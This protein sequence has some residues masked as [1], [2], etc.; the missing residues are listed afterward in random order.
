MIPI[1]KELLCTLGP[2]SMN[3]RVIK[4]LEDIGATLFRINLSHTPLDAV[5]RTV[6]LIQNETAVPICLDTEG[7]QIRTGDIV[8]SEIRL[9]ENGVVRAHQRRTAGDDGNF[10]FYPRNIVASL[11]IGDFISIDFDAV[12]VQVIGFEGTGADAV[13]VMRV[14]NGGP[15][16]RNKAVTVARDIALPPMTEKDREAVAIGAALGV[17]HF[18]LSFANCRADVE[19]LRAIAGPDAFVISKIECLRGIA[20]L[21]EIA[22]ASEAILIDRGD[23]SREVPMENIPRVQKQII[24][25]GRRSGVRV[26]VATN[27]LESMVSA[28]SPTRAEVNDIFNTLEDGADG[29]VLAAETA[30]G[31]FPIECAGM[32]VKMIRNFE[33]PGPESGGDSQFSTEPVSLLPEPHGGALV[34][35]EA[36]SAERAQADALPVLAVR[37]TDFMDCEQIA[38]GTYSP[39]QGF[40]DRATLESVLEGNRLPCGAIWTLPVILQVADDE[41]ARLG[42]GARIVLTDESGAGRALMDV[43]ETYRLDLDKVAERWFGTASGNHPG[44]ARFAAAGPTAVAGPVTLLDRAPSRWRHFELTPAQTRFV[45]AHKGW[46]KVVGFHTRNVVHRVHHYIQNAAL[47]RCDADGLY[48]SPVIGPKKTHDFLPGPIMRSYQLLLEFGEYAAGKVVLGSFST[49]SRYCGPREAV[50]T[51]LCRK[52]MG[53]SHFIIGRDHTGVGAYYAPDD[54]RRLFDAVG[55]IG[56]EPVFFD[57]IG[58]NV[59]TDA[60]GPVDAAPTVRTISGTQARESLIAAERLPGWFMHDVVQDMLLDEIRSG[61]PVF[62]A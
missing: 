14:L 55:D 20:N 41:A 25:R 61:R 2:A 49:W 44:V 5:E 21:D 53:C 45:F 43:T 40:M 58:Y 37:T 18:A 27:L 10:N 34:R 16:R 1:G 56:I 29:L 35:R 22:E 47:E 28:P 17:R 3:G 13:A 4:R 31:R 24:A 57:N 19:A 52:N 8:D 33:R 15:V 60:Y 23:L 62:F 42:P 30:I 26:Y 54:N 12:L 46:S 11:A 51:A 50:F 38:L 36:T 7:A 59:E 6:R 32:I 9:R 48:I 39:L